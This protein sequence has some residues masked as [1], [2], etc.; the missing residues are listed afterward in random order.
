MASGGTLED[1]AS[2]HPWN[3]LILRP[4]YSNLPTSALPA[5]GAACLASCYST[6]FKVLSGPDTGVLMKLSASTPPSSCHTS[7]V[8][9]SPLSLRWGVPS[10]GNNLPP[11]PPLPNSC[12]SFRLMLP[13][14]SLLTRTPPGRRAG[15]PPSSPSGITDPPPLQ[16]SAYPICGAIN[17]RTQACSMRWVLFQD[18]PKSQREEW[19]MSRH[20]CY[21]CGTGRRFDHL[22]AGG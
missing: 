20:L 22:G 14:K 1:S 16:H 3:A 17:A 15:G 6:S 18:L 13:G 10:I 19:I 5:P 9:F 4:D 8:I 2:L 21:V 12:S 11:T 7:C